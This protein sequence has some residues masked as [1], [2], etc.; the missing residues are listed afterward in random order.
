MLRLSH[1]DQ[2]VN[3]CQSV[4]KAMDVKKPINLICGQRPEIRTNLSTLHYKA[5]GVPNFTIYPCLHFLDIQKTVPTQKLRAHTN[6]DI[7]AET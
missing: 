2:K 1:Y 6:S 4:S 5:L 7:F 3:F